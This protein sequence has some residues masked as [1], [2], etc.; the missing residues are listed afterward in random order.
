MTAG[1]VVSALVMLAAATFWASCLYD[2]ARTEESD[3]RTY[4]RQ[5]WLV[6]LVFLNVFGGLMWLYLGRPQPPTRR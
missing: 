1:N 3:V 6:L 2:L 4:P 5:V